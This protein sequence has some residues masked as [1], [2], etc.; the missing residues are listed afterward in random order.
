[1]KQRFLKTLYLL[2]TIIILFAGCSH[3]YAENNLVD[4][5]IDSATKKDRVEDTRRVEEISESE[6]KVSNQYFDIYLIREGQSAFTGKVTYTVKITSHIDSPETQLQWDYPSTLEI[7][8]K[9]KEF[10]NMQKGVTYTLKALVKPEKDG[11]FPITFTAISWQHNTNYTN[12]A[13]DDITFDES[14]VLQPVSQI[15]VIGNI[16]KYLSILLVAGGLIFGIIKTVKGLSP[17]AKKWL[18]PPV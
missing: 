7:T 3:V 14:L 5:L 1:M 11:V 13:S 17:K 2:L 6:T 9:H 10:M 12:S 18:T 16:V 8:P 4:D 15:Y